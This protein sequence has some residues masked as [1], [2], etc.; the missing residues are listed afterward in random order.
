MRRARVI[1]GAALLWAGGVGGPVAGCGSTPPDEGG[2]AGVSASSAGAERA[3]RP[4]APP[5]DP[6]RDAPPRDGRVLSSGARFAELVAAARRQDQLRDQDS[7]AGCLLRLGPSPRL[8]A[9]L[10]AAVRPL[11]EPP[12][13]LAGRLGSVAVLTRYGALG[14]PD[15]ALGLVAFTTTPPTPGASARVVVVTGDGLWLATTEGTSARRIGR[16]ALSGL[17]DGRALVAVTAEAGITVEAVG[18][19]LAALPASLAGRVTLAVA[20]PEG[21]RLP[22]PPSVE[23]PAAAAVCE[24]EPMP[25]E[26]WG[27]LDGAALRRG[28][29]PLVDRAQLCVGTTEGA[30]ALGGRVVLSMRIGPSGRVTAAC[31]SEDA[32]GDGVLRACLVGAAR[33]LVFEAPSGGSVDVALPLRL[34]PGPAHRQAALCR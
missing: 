19:V 25:D 2:P 29:A 4:D 11:P 24:L 26:A 1:L 28:V 31:V 14:A 23:G 15:A 32:T 10:A 3:Q 27:E 13:S 21:T 7:A 8:E 17:D 16:D 20:L 22:A 18:A 12:P 6:T 30:G 33:E 5:Q 34:E 9:D